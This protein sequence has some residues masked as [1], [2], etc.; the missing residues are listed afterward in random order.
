MCFSFCL[1]CCC[2]SCVLSR[3]VSWRCQQQLLTCN[4]FDH[5]KWYLHRFVHMTT[6][7]NVDD[8]KKITKFI[9]FSFVDCYSLSLFC[10]IVTVILILYR[11]KIYDKYLSDSIKSSVQSVC[12]YLYVVTGALL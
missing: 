8:D 5:F 11:M 12:V 3:F 9:K 4:C 7:N 6:T 2:C 10:C 1:I